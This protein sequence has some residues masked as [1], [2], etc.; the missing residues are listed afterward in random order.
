M[1]NQQQKIIVGQYG[2]HGENIQAWFTGILFPELLLCVLPI[3]VHYGTQFQKRNSSNQKI[4]WDRYCKLKS[5]PD[6]R[7]ERK[8]I[9]VF[10]VDASLVQIRK[11]KLSGIS[12]YHKLINRLKKTK[13]TRRN[14][15]V[16]TA[17]NKAPPVLK[18]DQPP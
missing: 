5:H 11:P 2:K 15:A 1:R 13:P 6:R 18:H 14:N 7:S 16:P 12:T 17:R 9:F 10:S 3:L 8:Q 4:K